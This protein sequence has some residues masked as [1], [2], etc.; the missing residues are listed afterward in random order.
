[1]TIEFRC[2]A[3]DKLL[4]TAD[5]KAGLVA[6]CPDCGELVDIPSP[7]QSVRDE[8]F[9]QAFGSGHFAPSRAPAPLPERGVAAPAPPGPA[10]FTATRRC[11][12]CGETIA[13]AAVLCRFC[14]TTLGPERALR[15]AASNSLAITSMVLGITSIPMLC[16]CYTGIP[17]GIAAVTTGLIAVKQ[18]N[19]GDATGKELA[20]VG[21]V[22][23]TLP[24]LL[25][26]AFFAFAIVAAVND[27]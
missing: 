18:C 17:L 13:A 14:G 27:I 19:R 7:S 25:A 10:Q 2:P 16:A 8:R 21:I 15:P 1:M 20:I 3:C 26:A 11:P 6:N 24:M 22:C 4:R 23:G 5:D 12:M 9:P